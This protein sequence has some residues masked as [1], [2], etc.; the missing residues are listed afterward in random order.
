MIQF[1]HNSALQQIGLIHQLATRMSLI[2]GG[3]KMDYVIHKGIAP[4]VGRPELRRRR[5]VMDMVRLARHM[6]IGDCVEL[7]LSDANTFRTVMVALG[8]GVMCVTDGWRCKTR[9]KI[10]AFKVSAA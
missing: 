1:A 6:E 8:Q 2:I 3:D 4:P 7:T 10:L 5:K 9:G